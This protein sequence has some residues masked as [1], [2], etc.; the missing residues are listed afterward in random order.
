MKNLDF[1]A[2]YGYVGRIST[3]IPQDTV[4]ISIFDN[5]FDGD[6]WFKDPSITLNISNSFG[7]PIRN[8]FGD[9]QT[10]SVKNGGIWENHDF[11]ID[12][13]SINYPTSIGSTAYQS[14]LLN[15]DNFSSIRDLVSSQPKYLFFEVDS[16][17]INPD[18]YNQSSINFVLDTSRVSVDMEVKLPLEGNAWYSLVDTLELDIEDNFED[19]SKHFIEA[20]LRIIF[21]NFLPTDAY[22][23]VIFTDSLYQPID[24]LFKNNEQIS[25]QYDGERLLKSAILD[26]NGRALQPVKQI[27]DILFGNGSEY[28]HDIN[29][30]ERVKNAIIIA[31]LRTNEDGLVGGAPAPIVKFYADNY[32]EVK[33]GVKGQ[34]KYEEPLN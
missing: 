22:V 32:L 33:F 10:F 26:N 20:N 6:V 21:D 4:N 23:Q 30:L 16:V 28:N 12:E 15:I 3:P 11:P 13:L 25:S 7:L 18:N 17:I 24:T 34:G 19:I 5:A 14:E 1:D 2:I 31:T 29:D 8:Y 27:T 9:L